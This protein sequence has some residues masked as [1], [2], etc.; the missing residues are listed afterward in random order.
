MKQ[1]LLGQSVEI[2]ESR[3]RYNEYRKRFVLEAQQAAAR[4][5]AAYRENCGLVDVINHAPEQIHGAIQPTI[6]FCIQT[7]VDHGVLTIDEK[8][9]EE[10]YEEALSL[11]QKP[12][13]RICDQYADITMEQDELDAY[14]VARR[15]NRGRWVGGGFGL[16]GAIKGAATAG[17]L[18]MVSGAAHMVVNGIGKIFSSASA[19]SAIR[20]IFENK[21][22]EQS[23][24]NSVYNITFRLRYCL[25]DCLNK[26]DA[27]TISW[28]GWPRSSEIDRAKSILNN[29]SRI[30]DQ[31][32]KR[33]A[34]LEAFQLNPYSQDW[35]IIALQEFGDADGS[36]EA[37]AE[38]FGIAGL[39]QAKQDNL[40]AFAEALSLDT[41]A[42][43]QKAL[44]QIQERQKWLGYTGETEHTNAAAKAASCFDLHY[45]TVDDCVFLTREEAD[46]VRAEFAKIQEIEAQTDMDDIASVES[47]RQQL[48][49]YHSLVAQK[50]QKL[51]ADRWD[52]LDRKQRSVFTNLPNTEPIL[53]DSPEAAAALQ[54]IA[55]QLTQGIQACKADSNPEAALQAIQDRIHAEAFPAQVRDCYAAE[56]QRL[57]DEIDL[58][59]RTAFEKEYPSRENAA[60]AKQVYAGIESDIQKQNLQTQADALRKRI[61][62]SD[63]SVTA[64]EKLRTKLFQK[65]HAAQI[66]TAK[67]FG[68]ISG[69]LLVGLI[70]ISYLFKLS[71]TVNFAH[72]QHMF[73]GI[74][75]MIRETAICPQLSFWDGMKN[76][77][78][79][80]GHCIGEIFINGFYAYVAGFG[81]GLLHSIIWAVLGIFWV[82]IKYTVIAIPRLILCTIT[83]FF[84]KGSLLYYAGYLLGM[85]LLLRVLLA[86]LN[87]GEEEARIR[88]NSK[89]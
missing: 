26:S 63:L 85:Y 77:L 36:L 66:R 51:M 27:D 12:Y 89:K 31:D 59:E 81:R 40:D 3:V 46:S 52:E 50:H 48:Q 44:I 65:E 62:A 4:F 70:L 54:K 60:S 13:L 88:K 42:A 23:L 11:W 45:R 8:K 87:K 1:Q 49:A 38:Y 53:L 20:K 55:D 47:A 79:V 80:F 72:T 17:A 39:K 10:L 61:D 24:E 78:V 76:A 41:E 56:V 68:N 32:A 69:W 86:Y 33:A 22:T 7:L 43:A 6:H 57:L 74:S 14:R 9:F 84:Q 64:K 73:L 5:Q 75:F 2:T 71:C 82:L 18:N 58:Q 21:D 15:E 25:L 67:A 16:G 83:V 35:Y 19:S 28:Q 34:L 29:I 30:S 37:T